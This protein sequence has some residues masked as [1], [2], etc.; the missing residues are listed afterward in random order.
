MCEARW[1]WTALVKWLGRRDASLIRF[2]M[3]DWGIWKSMLWKV[4]SRTERE[5]SLGSCSR[6]DSIDRDQG[7][8]GTRIHVS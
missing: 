2:S 8:S 7:V 3:E 6:V 1:D 5:A 4:F